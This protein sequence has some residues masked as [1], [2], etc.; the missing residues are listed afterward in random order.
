MSTLFFIIGFFSF[1]AILVFGGLWIAAIGKKNEENKKKF[2]KMAGISAGAWLLSSIIFGASL[3]S[4]ETADQKEQVIEVSGETKSNTVEKKETK[5]ELSAEEKAEAE[6]KKK[7]EEAR[8]KKE[9][10]EKAKKAEEDRIA[11]EKAEEERLAREAELAKEL[12]EALAKE[13]AER[14][15]N[16][17]PIPYAQLKKNPDRYAYEYVKYTGEIIQI[18]EGDNITNIRLAVTKTSYGYDFSDIVFIEYVGYTDFVDG[19]VVTV[20]GYVYGSY[21][22]ES[23]AGYNITLPGILAD[24]VVSP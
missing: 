15:A 4:S 23:Q 1:I 11:K 10:E 14:K 2:I 7:E 20:Y 6:V 5:K 8:L 17:Q 13:E 22:Y 24:E 18:L 21:T 12:E 9:E 3:S 19:D 16:A